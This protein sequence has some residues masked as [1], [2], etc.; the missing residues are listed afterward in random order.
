MSDM[1]D[2]G[3]QISAS[4]AI[5]VIM[6]GN[7]PSGSPKEGFGL[8]LERLE[9]FLRSDEF[10]LLDSAYVPLFAEYLKRTAGDK[11]AAIVDRA[12]AQAQEESTKPKP[13][14]WWWQ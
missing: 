12:I 3:K 7:M 9:S 4:E 5:L 13:I 10:G 8:H 14:P 1:S 11:Y 2:G 6:D